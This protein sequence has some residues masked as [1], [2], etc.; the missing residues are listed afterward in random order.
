MPLKHIDDLFQDTQYDLDACLDK[1]V[2]WFEKEMRKLEREYGKQV[3]DPGNMMTAQQR[4]GSNGLTTTIIPGEFYM[5]LHDPIQKWSLPYYDILPLTFVFEAGRDWFRGL[6]FHYLPCSLRVHLLQ[7]LMKYATIK[8]V[9]NKTRILLDWE[10][11]KNSS[12]CYLVQPCEQRYWMGE[13]RT[14]FKL[15][16]PRHWALMMMLPCEN[17]VKEHKLMVWKN[18]MNHSTE[19]VKDYVARIGSTE[20]SRMLHNRT[21]SSQGPSISI[22]KMEE[23]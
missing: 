12:S 9:N 10:E 7:Y 5:F 19:V 21:R 17:F 2:E 6:N 14:E 18:T 20:L 4:S 1:P 8:P 15:I 11:A 23:V 3:S 16:E 22:T 13:A